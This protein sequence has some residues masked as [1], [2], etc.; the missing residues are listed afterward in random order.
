MPPSRGK[1]EGISA[2]G[3][4][5]KGPA[6]YPVILRML[7]EGDGLKIEQLRNV[8]APVGMEYQKAF[9]VEVKDDSMYPRYSSGDLILVNAEIEPQT[10]DYAAVR[11]RGNENLLV[12]RVFIR[13]TNIA[14]VPLNPNYDAIPLEREEIAFWAPIVYAQSGRE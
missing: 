5:K 11:F 9:W 10:G 6:G 7:V 12:R 13:G 3:K 8:N 4:T 1:A 14:L 2:Q